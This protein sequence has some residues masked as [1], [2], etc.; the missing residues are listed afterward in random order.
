MHYQ[1]FLMDN[2][3]LHAADQLSTMLASA[4]YGHIVKN[5]KS[6]ALPRYG[7][8]KL[9]IKESCSQNTLLVRARN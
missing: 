5:V 7:S 2:G 6:S 4:M 1:I 9:C 8:R 3:I